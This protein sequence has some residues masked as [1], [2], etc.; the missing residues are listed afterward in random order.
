MIQVKLPNID[1]TFPQFR[2][3]PQMVSVQLIILGLH[4]SYRYLLAR[5]PRQIRLALHTGPL[6]DISAADSCA[7]IFG[8]LAVCTRNPDTI[9]ASFVRFFRDSYTHRGHWR[10]RRLHK[11]LH[12]N[13]VD[14]VLIRV[15]KQLG[16]ADPIK[17]VR[18]NDDLLGAVLG[19]QD[20]ISFTTIAAGGLFLSVR[21]LSEILTR[22]WIGQSYLIWSG[23]SH[24]WACS[25]YR[26]WVSTM[27]FL[28]A[29]SVTHI[30]PPRQSSGLPVQ[31][32]VSKEFPSCPT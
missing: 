9:P 17:F 6:L 23:T 21:I 10:S 29:G 11:G 31:W 8:S 18:E 15:Q 7:E 19:L 13:I 14:T 16:V 24:N 4:E 3:V 1:S 12:H 32:A 28:D 26:A 25:A 5:P 22:N 2:A 27:L 20:L 30:V